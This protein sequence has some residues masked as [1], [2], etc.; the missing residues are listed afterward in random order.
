M[1]RGRAQSDCRRV[2]LFGVPTILACGP[3][4]LSRLILQGA[5]TLPPH[6]GGSRALRGSVGCLSGREQELAGVEAM[7]RAATHQLRGSC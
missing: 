7:L 3:S 6:S 1:G 2:L 4:A 5:Q